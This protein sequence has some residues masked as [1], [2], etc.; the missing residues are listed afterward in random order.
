MLAFIDL[1]SRV[2]LDHPLRSI[3]RFADAALAELSGQFDELYVDGGRASVP[4]ER[5][6]K[7]SLLIS[8][9]SVSGWPHRPARLSR[10]PSGAAWPL[11]GRRQ[12]PTSTRPLHPG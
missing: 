9:Y 10:S 12:T 11:P 7:A 3:K 5:L 4:P 2:P 1:E 6:L 8:L